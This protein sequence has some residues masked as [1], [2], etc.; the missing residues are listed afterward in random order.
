MEIVVDEEPRFVTVC[1]CLYFDVH[2]RANLRLKLL[3]YTENEDGRDRRGQRGLKLWQWR[4]TVRVIHRCILPR[5][6]DPS[7]TLCPLCLS[8]CLHPQTDRR[9]VGGDNG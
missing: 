1:L 2:L 4:R 5:S 9:S 6:S 7:L 3:T 8:V